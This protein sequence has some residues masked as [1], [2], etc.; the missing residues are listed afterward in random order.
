MRFFRAA[1]VAPCLP[2]LPA[3]ANLRHVS[4]DC[5][6]LV[7]GG[8]VAG[9]AAALAAARTG[10][11]TLLVRA[12]PGASAVSLGGWIG[13]PPAPFRDALVAAGL[14][15]ELATATLPRPDGTT[16]RVDAAPRS[17]L[18]AALSD[19]SGLTLVCGID[20]LSSFQPA[21]LAALWS[22]DHA[23]TP[24]TITLPDTPPAGWSPVSLA[25]LLEREPRR[26]A[27]PLVALIREH[28]ATRVILPAVL[29]LE[30]HTA[31]HE[32]L[33]AH[34]NARIGEALGSAP[35][36][37]GWRLDVALRAALEQAGVRSIIARVTDRTARAQRIASVSLDNG[38][39]LHGGAIVLATGKYIGGG[40]VADPRFTESALGCAVT[41]HWL[42]RT[43]DDAAASVL[44]TSEERSDAQPLLE[45]GVATDADARPLTATGDIAYDNVFVAGSVRAGATASL[46]LGHA[47]SEGWHAGERAAAV[48]ASVLSA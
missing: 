1:S 46:G 16:V 7:L 43:F 19:E 36:L 32:A 11:R 20:G 47:A 10:A 18:H 30:R 6:V 35:S 2:A 25:A 45:V 26:I 41:L 8:G 12:A 5:D 33:E 40:I 37:P 14:P 13:A 17:H 3:C 21:P 48:A 15:L 9:T 38:E 44:V 24:V 39:T 28:R 31:M 4:D 42:G 29:G 27:E 23:L 34:A 22:D